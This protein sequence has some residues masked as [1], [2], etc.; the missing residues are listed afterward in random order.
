M[1]GDIPGGNIDT[2]I[3]IIVFPV[4]ILTLFFGLRWNCGT[5]WDQYYNI[6]R[7]VKW[8]NFYNMNRYGNDAQLVEPGFAFVNVL[9]KTIGNGSYTFYLLITNLCRFLLM[10]Y[11]S[12]KLSK[13]PVITFFGFLSLQYMFP[14]RNPYATAVFFVGFIFILK[15]D[16]LHYTLVWLGAVSIHVSSVLVF[17]L[18]YLYGHRLKFVWQLV[19]YGSTIIFAT[20]FS[21]ALQM[22]GSLLTLGYATIDEKIATY[23]QAFREIESSRGVISMALPVFFLCLFEWVR[24]KRHIFMSKKMLKNYDFFVICYIMATGLWNLLMNSMPD[25]CRYVEFI[26]TWP[27]LMSFAIVKYR[28]FFYLIVV[29]LI[30]YYLYRMNNTINLGLYHDLFVPY[31]W[32]FD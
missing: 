24:Y 10:A 27:L 9:L 11:V 22:Y 13:T 1:F 12:F 23:T 16:L 3:K 2:K 28:E 32:I 7:S 15:R 6:F 29:V 18:Y 8:D 17:P 31:R 20:V 19:L 5:D 4:A 30:L 26:N 25:L 21:K 14:T